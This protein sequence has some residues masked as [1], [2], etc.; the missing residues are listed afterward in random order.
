[1]S[2]LQISLVRGS[3]YESPGRTFAVIFSIS[4]LALFSSCEDTSTSPTGA[5]SRDSESGERHLKNIRQLTH[6]GENA[7]AYFSFDGSQLVFQAREVPSDADAKEPCD[8]IYRMNIDGS[9]RSL[10][11]T[12]KGRTTCAFFTAFDTRIVYASTHLDGDDCPPMPKFE[13]RGYVWPIFASYDIFSARPDGTGLLRLTETDGYDAEATLSG[14]GS[15]IVFTSIRDGDLD[16]YTMKPDGSQQRRVT[17]ALGYDGGGF[18]SPDGTRI[19]Y[20][21]YHPTGDEETKRYKDLLARQLVE[22]S[23]MEIFVCNV[24]GTDVRQVAELG[25]ANFC[26]FFHPSGEKI[27]FATNHHNEGPRKRN[28]DLFM[29]DL[30]GENLERLTFD[31][32]F[33]GFPMFSPDGKTLVWCSN[34]FAAQEGDT[35]VFIADWIE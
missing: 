35:N 9:A 2:A 12:G 11:S 6:G 20:R 16:L 24:D 14:D 23:R 30:D 33:D 28:F 19:C 1:M 3:R 5:V 15:L 21:A 27:I 22:P 26:P 34:R 13:G 25:N 32:S 17:S 18:L 7:E 8:Q 29:V 31:D 4:F 10:V